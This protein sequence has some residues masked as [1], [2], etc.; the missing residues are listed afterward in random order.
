MEVLR[1]VDTGI[2]EAYSAQLL[3]ASGALRTPQEQEEAMQRLL[4]VI[5]LLYAESGEAYAQH[6]KTGIQVVEV[7]VQGSKQRIIQTAVEDVPTKIRLGERKS[8]SV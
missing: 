8:A 2:V 7:A 4:E 1:T 3:Q 6:L 5:D